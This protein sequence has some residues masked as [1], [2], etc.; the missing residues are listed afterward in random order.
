MNKRVLFI[1]GMLL[2]FSLVLSYSL[3]NMYIS[4][5]KYK[6]GY[7][8]SVSN[9]AGV[10]KNNSSV[11]NISPKKEK[12]ATP[13]V[14]KTHI[15]YSV[16]PKKSLFRPQRKEWTPPPPPS[17]KKKAPPP[18]PKKKR[19]IPL[20]QLFGT[21]IAG[22]T[23]IAI[24]QGYIREGDIPIFKE[25]IISGR[26]TRIPLPPIKGKLVK[27]KMKRYYVGDVI[28]DVKI[29][30]IKQDRVLVE[31]GKEIKEILL[32]GKAK[33]K[34]GKNESSSK[35]RGETTN[36]SLVPNK[37]GFAVSGVRTNIGTHPGSRSP[38]KQSE[39]NVMQMPTNISGYRMGGICGR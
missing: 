39:G 1:N 20:P 19:T 35:Q 37:G 26:K 25:V 17:P 30:D 10:D 28:S 36:F 3:A 27:E 22:K 5:R 11:N 16:I 32:K 15:D 34:E 9:R 14:K 12:L 38:T 8:E 33:Q 7:I 24:M 29:V 2:L 13:L 23:K 31:D 4:F 18:P 6:N 21:V